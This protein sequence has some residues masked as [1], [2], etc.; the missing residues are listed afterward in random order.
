MAFGEDGK[1]KRDN[2][3][4]LRKVVLSVWDKDGTSQRNLEMFLDS[5]TKLAN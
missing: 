2:V 1:I 3:L 5:I 4:A